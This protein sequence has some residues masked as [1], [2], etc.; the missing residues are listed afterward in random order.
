MLLSALS[1]AALASTPDGITPADEDVCDAY[2]GAAYGTCVA[3]C[4]ATDCDEDPNASDRACDAL[5]DRFERL[6]GEAP[7]CEAREYDVTFVYSGDDTVYTWLDGVAFAAAANDIYWSRESTR[8]LVL[9]SGTYTFAVRTVDT[10]R[11]YVGLGYAIYVDGAAWSTSDDL[12]A[13]MT[14]TNPGTGWESPTYDD[15]AWGSP[16]LCSPD[17]WN[18]VSMPLLDAAGARWIWTSTSCSYYT[19]QPQTWT[20]ITLTLP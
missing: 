7:P 11:G 4:E 10:G 20:R 3:Y 5:Y 16:L 13:A 14:S 1:F 12:D 19:S 15:S 18:S 9:S 2:A 8:N 6:T 17:P